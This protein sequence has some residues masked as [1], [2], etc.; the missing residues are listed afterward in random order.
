VPSQVLAQY[1]SVNAKAN[2]TANTP[3]STYG[4]Q[5]VAPVNS[6]Q[7]AGI[8]GT[9][10]YANEAQPYFGAATNTL[11]AAQAGTQPYNAAAAG[12]L[13]NAQA[14]TNPTNTAALGLA[15]ASAEQVN[16][17]P[18]T[19]QSINQFM[20]P[21]LQDVVG[22][23]AA[24]LNQQNQQQ[25][26]G[27]LGNAINSGAF[28]GDR[29]G[30]AAANL[31]E[32][33]NLANSQI[34]SG[35]LNTGFNTALGAAQQQQGVNLEAGQANRAALASAGQELA[36]IGQTQYG[37]GAN[38]ASQYAGLGQT[39]YGE[40]ANTATELAGL[41]S[42][43]QSAGLQGAQAQ[44]G[45]GTLEQQTQQAQDTAQYNQFEQQQSY[46]FQVDQ[47]LAN[48]AEG[49]GALSGSTTTTTQPG[50][51]FSDE[52]LKHSKKPIG[53]TYDGQTIY[54]YKMHGDPR[55]HVGLMAQEVEKKHPGAVG[56]AAGYKTVDYGKATAKAANEGHFALGGVV[57]MRARKAAGGGMDG[58]DLE[59]IL[60]AQE[61]MYAGLG[62][63]RMR[64]VG[65]LP[66]G[67]AANVPAPSGG[68]PQL[69]TA[70]GGLRAQPTGAQNMA[71]VGQLANTYGGL[72]KSMG[73]PKPAGGWPWESTTTNTTPG[74]L[75][76]G[77]ANAQANPN[78]TV[79]D[80]PQGISPLTYDTPQ[81]YTSAPADDSG[82]GA[83][84]KRGGRIHRDAGGDTPYS[85]S[86]GL[87]IPNENAHNQLSKPA[88]LPPPS[89]TG[90]QQL[91]SAGSGMGGMGGMMGGLGGGDGGS[92]LDSSTLFD[93][94]STGAAIGG[95]DAALN[96]IYSVPE[97]RGGRIKKDGG[98]GFDADSAPNSSGLGD[99]SDTSVDQASALKQGAPNTSLDSVKHLAL[100]AGEAYIGDYP[101][102]A[103][104]LYDT[105]NST[106]TNN[107][108]RGGRI[109]KDAGGGTG[110]PDIQ[111]VPAP[112]TP[113]GQM[114][115][116]LTV[117]APRPTD[118][119]GLA[120]VSTT[121]QRMD[122]PSD[123]LAPS[124]PGAPAPTSSGTPIWDKI[125]GFLGDPHNLMPILAGVGAMGTAPTKHLGVALA[126]GMQGA[127]QN[128]VPT[129]EGLARTQVLG[130]QAQGVNIQNQIAQMRATAANQFMNG[131]GSPSQIPTPTYVAPKIDP[132]QT[133]QQIDQ[134]YRNM[135]A[136]QPWTPQELARRDQA[137]NASYAM[138]NTPINQVMADRSA[139]IDAQTFANQQQA[140][141][142][143]DSLYAL[144]TQAP[145]QATRDAA[146]VR[147][148]AIHQFTGDKYDNLAGAKVNTRTG[149]PAIGVATQSLTPEQ[150]T[151][152]GL[153]TRGQDIS[154]FDV[155]QD[156]NG[157]LFRVNRVSG[158]MTPVGGGSATPN[159]PLTLVPPAKA[160]NAP[161]S[162]TVPPRTPPVSPYL[163]G[164]D[165]NSL[166][167]VN[168]ATGF[169]TK[170]SNVAPEKRE[171][172]RTQQLSDASDASMLDAKT[173]SILTAAQK[174]VAALANNPRAVGPGSET[175]NAYQKFRTAVTG[176]P[177]DQLVNQEELDKFLNQVGA[178][179]VRTL[180]QGQKITN[181]EMM[182]FMTR[183]SPNVSQPLPVIRNLVNY[184]AADNEYDQRL[185]ATKISALQDTTNDPYGLAGAIETAPGAGRAEY[186]QSKLGFS[187]SFTPKQRPGQVSE[188][189]A[190]VAVPTA[191]GPN[192]EKVYLRGGKWVSQ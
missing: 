45:A 182:T 138:G 91:M 98:G 140:Q 64:A 72:Y 85:D 129:Q 75:S 18:I 167:K 176:A 67:G 175:Y 162:P 28:G 73:S 192:G 61:Q 7:T 190:I 43:A 120:P 179:N 54:S 93:S 134:E 108:R 186:V 57:P 130:Q 122:V 86:G 173:R 55:T 177:P 8:S 14:G 142:E 31:E 12:T 9:N 105:Y 189:P 50:G 131:T 121:A 4:G 168:A 32:Q 36:G 163:P 184:L 56:L 123:G 132:T 114:L 23:E 185:Q 180:L 6:Q 15:G 107:H 16:A 30:I 165:F 42:G 161:N 128:Y 137:Y 99:A 149:A 96:A 139:R 174:E 187:P 10:A 77:L 159:G 71:A 157:N 166:P 119:A 51:F 2:T 95:D 133:A 147:Y 141:H 181:Q 170:T 38:T 104:Q 40:G 111:D 46:P 44:I 63:G 148:N 88:A 183:G 68:T 117:E 155:K 17:Q 41:G 92:G 89:P 83:P 19:A 26:A 188:G 152:A 135:Y 109:G 22:S 80:N 79:T 125:K 70:Q 66:R 143:A 81:N 156:D 87:D 158:A 60:A 13:G 172:F 76:P 69:V 29:T 33:Q 127:A 25:A 59:A 84:Q 103:M 116:E 5:F 102:A 48:I 49:T 144:A 100:A 82:L 113:N 110:D 34:Y 78:T 164:V 21:Y 178:Q 153:T 37:E 126:A 47:F 106:Q 160:P 154:M 53:K 3:F 52:R 101:G 146:L 27:Q 150:S 191:T 74:G 20:S 115:D 124:A 35:L 62:G 145:D 94:G 151:Q 118:D 11:G 39:A 1:Q 171:E 136:V 24:V 112:A 90:F 58:S 97:K 65:G 169:A